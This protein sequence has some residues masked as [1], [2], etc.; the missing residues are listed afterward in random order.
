MT[1]IL[2]LVADHAFGEPPLR[3]HPVV[4][5][6]RFL[7]LGG[8]SIPATNSGAFLKGA[9]LW[10]IGAAIW[11]GLGLAAE[12]WLSRLGLWAVPATALVAFPFLSLRLLCREVAEVEI[13]LGTG[14]ETGR[15]Q[16]SRIVS[17]K[18][19]ALSATE[20]RESALESLAENLTDSVT[21]PLFWLLLLGLPGIMVY[22]FANTADAMWGYRDH[23][24]HFG[25]WAAHADDVLNW[26]PSRLTGL[27]LCPVALWPR[28][29][30]ESRLTPSPNGGWT[31]GAM[32]LR[33][34]VRLGKP[35][36]YTLNSGAPAPD[37]PHV[38]Q[39]LGSARQVAWLFAG[40]ASLIQVLWMAFHA[41]F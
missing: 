12:H 29:S 3:L 32:A 16:L 5:M 35:G 41:R 6:G 4:W 22:R 14:L 23:R 10:I 7:G 20:V 24:E 15:R 17:R 38:P 8:K 27:L 33:L 31:M 39:A 37:S 1:P 21:A 36:V 34:G 26:I 2:A 30:R 28:L 11:A 40:L 9:I 25:K 19:G 18:T 13:A